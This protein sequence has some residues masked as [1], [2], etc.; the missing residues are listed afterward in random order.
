MSRLLTFER[1]I[2]TAR[3]QNV[4]VIAAAGDIFDSNN[5]PEELICARVCQNNRSA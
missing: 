3:E 1:I 5:V 2:D 4:Q